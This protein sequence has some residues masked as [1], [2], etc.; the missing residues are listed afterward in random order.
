M[1]RLK[2]ICPAFRP[3]L[4]SHSVLC[5]WTFVSREPR[6]DLSSSAPK[7]GWRRPTCL[8]Q[9]R[10]VENSWVAAAVLGFLWLSILHPPPFSVVFLSKNRGLPN[11]LKH[12]P[13]PPA[14]HWDP[15]CEYFQSSH[16]WQAPEHNFQHATVA[17][18]FPLREAYCSGSLNFH[19]FL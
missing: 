6:K 3:F 4:V 13:S 17:S 19:F 1:R 2:N 11:K 15:D 8:P 10:P 9:P 12:S 18:H 5:H 14:Y 16:M 7:E